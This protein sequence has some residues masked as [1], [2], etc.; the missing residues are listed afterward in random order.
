MVPFHPG[1]DNN[2][3]RRVAE[4]EDVDNVFHRAHGERRLFRISLNQI[5][6]AFTCWLELDQ[7]EHS[8]TKPICFD[9]GLSILW[10]Y[11]TLNDGNMIIR[12]CGMRQPGLAVSNIFSFSG[13]STWAEV[14]HVMCPSCLLNI[15]DIRA[16]VIWHFWNRYQNVR[17]SNLSAEVSEAES[18]RKKRPELRFVKTTYIQSESLLCPR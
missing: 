11:W 9:A 12:L 15:W 14:G 18:W 1:S 17:M 4:W 16:W 10:K 6:M 13:R 8:S 7:E 5:L 3:F 2:M